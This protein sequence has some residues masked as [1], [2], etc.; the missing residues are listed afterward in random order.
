M[1][2]H[3][4]SSALGWFAPSQPWAANAKGAWDKPA[5]VLVLVQAAPAQATRAGP[6]V[7]VLDSR[8]VWRG[9]ENRM[10]W[11]PITR[12]SRAVPTTCLENIGCGG[13]SPHEPPHKVNTGTG[14]T[15][16]DGWLSIDVLASALL[17]WTRSSPGL[18]LPL[19]RPGS[20]EVRL[21]AAQQDD[22]AAR[23]PKLC[24]IGKLDGIH[25]FSD[26]LKQL[27]SFDNDFSLR[28]VGEGRKEATIPEWYRATHVLPLRLHSL[29]R[30]R[31]ENSGIQ[32]LHRR[33]HAWLSAPHRTWILS[34]ATQT[35]GVHIPRQTM[36]LLW[37]DE[38]PV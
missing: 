16:H 18:S 37:A 27:K 33:I 35:L 19:S 30:R 14:A 31:C 29:M 17:T 13:I 9:W 26:I 4:R 22:N 1:K 36:R 21:A 6:S 11:R 7:R 15:S 32:V 2:S 3:M 8:P 34:F 10:N 24:I 5:P 12:G 38:C 25:D 28:I 20:V 23:R